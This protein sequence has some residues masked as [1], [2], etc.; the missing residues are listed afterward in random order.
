M[1]IQGNTETAAS[2]WRFRRSGHISGL[3]NCNRNVL[4]RGP[5]GEGEGGIR[6]SERLSERSETR[7]LHTPGAPHGRPNI[8]LCPLPSVR[9][10]L[11]RSVS[12]VGREANPELITAVGDPVDDPADGRADDPQGIN[13]PMPPYPSPD[14]SLNP[15]LDPSS[16]PSSD[17]SPEMRGTGSSVCRRRLCECRAAS[18]REGPSGIPKGRK[19]L[20]GHPR[21]PETAPPAPP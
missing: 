18:A 12:G 15:S 16:D 4:R 8:R 1:A 17:P 14:P 9:L 11:L 6:R 20:Q 10:P 3:D 5:G 13:F 21:S 2:E 19:R 7:T